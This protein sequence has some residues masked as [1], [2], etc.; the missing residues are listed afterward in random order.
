MRIN[1][2]RGKLKF[3]AAALLHDGGV[4]LPNPSAR[5]GR[6]AETQ[7]SEHT[8]RSNQRSKMEEVAPKRMRLV[9]AL[10]GANGLSISA[11][12]SVASDAPGLCIDWS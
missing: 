12:G 2:V 9:F 6:A 1:N 10:T 4:A 5:W 8:S 11:E 3:L 7:Q